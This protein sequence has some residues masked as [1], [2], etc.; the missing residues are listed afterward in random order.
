MPRR[1]LLCPSHEDAAARDAE[2]C[3]YFREHDGNR[4]SQWSG[5]YTDGTRFGI[6]W[7]DQLERVLGPAENLPLATAV[8]DEDGTLDWQPLPPP[9][10]PEKAAQ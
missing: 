8:A 4:G 6:E 1:F 3:A 2:A 7:D 9:T 10:Q 5:V